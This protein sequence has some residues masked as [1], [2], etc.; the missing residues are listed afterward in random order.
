MSFS[1][2][3]DPS[4]SCSFEFSIYSI[5]LRSQLSFKAGSCKEPNCSFTLAN[6]FIFQMRIEMR[7]SCVEKYLMTL[8]LWCPRDKNLNSET[9]SS[10]SD[11]YNWLL[12][13]Y[14][15]PMWD[16]PLGTGGAKSL[17]LSQ[18]GLGTDR[19]PWSFHYVHNVTV[20]SEEFENQMWCIESV[21]ACVLIFETLKWNFNILNA[22]F[23]LHHLTDVCNLI[24]WQPEGK[25]YLR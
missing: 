24:F 22:I 25:S 18:L 10:A 7:T 11:K 17:V 16:L 6:H 1:H 15:F 13:R 9:L 14:G 23:F 4:L 2:C 19:L 21:K 5:I 20:F 12:V 8:F 3:V